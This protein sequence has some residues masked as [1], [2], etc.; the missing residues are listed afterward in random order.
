M[1]SAELL[2]VI[3]QRI[4][5]KMRLRPDNRGGTVANRIDD[6]HCLVTFDGSAVAQ[7]VAICGGVNV[8]EGDRV[9]LVSVGADWVVIGSFTSVLGINTAGRSSAVTLPGGGGVKQYNGSSAD[10]TD[11]PHWTFTKRYSNTNVQ[12]FLSMSLYSSVATNTE[13]RLG[14]HINGV[15]YD[16]SKIYLNDTLKHLTCPTGLLYVEGIPAGEYDCYVHWRRVSGTGT[17][18]IDVNDWF[19]SYCTEYLT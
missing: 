11:E 5:D 12:L 15:D 19:T 13:A 10:D 17:L 16:L 14:I 7:P 4:D 6:T 8:R 1:I 2:A 18:N 3:D 9:V